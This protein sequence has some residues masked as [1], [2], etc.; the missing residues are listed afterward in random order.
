MIHQA[1]GSSLCPPLS[2]PSDPEWS[3]RW[4]AI[5][6]LS[7]RHYDLPRN[8]CGRRYVSLLTT[9]IQDLTRGTFP[10]ERALL[11]SS[12]ILQRDR[13]IKKGQDILHTRNRRM[14]LWELNNHDSLVQEA[15]RCDR[16]FQTRR[17]RKNHDEH[18]KRVFSRLML[19]GKIRAA[20][21]W[22]TNRSKGSVLSPNDQVP[23]TTNSTTTSISVLEALKQKHPQPHPPHSF[24]L[25]QPSSLPL[26]EDV[27]VTGAH[28]GNVAHRIQG[29]AGPTGC[30]SF[31]WQDIL[32]RFGSHSARLRDA[33]A[34]LTRHLANSLVEWDSVQ[35]LLANRL[36]ALDKCPGI[37]PIGVGET[38]R[39]IIG[40]TVCM[41]TRDDAE[42]VCGVSQLCA[43]LQSGIEGAIHTARDM[44]SDDDTGMLVMDAKN[45]FNSINR[46]SLLWNVRVLWPRASRYIF[47]TYRGWSSLI[48]KGCNE[49]IYSREG[50][51][52]G[53]PLSMFVYAIGTIPLI[54]KLSNTS[55]P[56]QLWYANDSS[57][58]G[59][60][61]V[62]RSWL[63]KLIEIG[64]LF[65]YFPEPKKSSLIVH[66]HLTDQARHIFQDSN[67][68][69]VTSCRFL[70]DSSSQERFVSMKAEQWESY[71]RMLTLV[72][73]D[74]P[75]EAY[76]ALTKSLQ[77]EWLYLQ[78]VTPNCGHL[79][80]SVEDSL[81]SVFIP[82]LIGHNVSSRDRT[83]FSLPV[84]FG[85]LN[86]R[87][88]TV[89]AE[90]LYGGNPS[91]Q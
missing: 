16:P 78:R 77:N 38:L 85:G 14:D 72:A 2:S 80:Q 56:T 1:Y 34:G 22:L 61:S 31:H 89:N 17:R 4:K 27:D 45:A 35:A 44:F 81:S 73:S 52:Q 39:R 36:I 59:N 57:A 91:T 13:T 30:D 23:S 54:Q 62:L 69:V 83:L 47:N 25:L 15:I 90:S 84:R 66:E 24:S 29:S 12:V 79:F 55:G 53:D 70:G 49:T 71:V 9:E 50:V 32:L 88:P 20:M 74:H 11:F 5:T 67:I 18:T 87:D 33:V 37:R 82:A 65:G 40:K 41:L 48:L 86:I 58:L 43:G 51:I 60:L 6:Q 76:I 19:L 42:S 10:S 7:G 46:L 68:A 63:D 3:T 28:V 26:L 75:Q 8:S 21:R 64:P